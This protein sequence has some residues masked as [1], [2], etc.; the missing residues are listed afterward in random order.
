MYADCYDFMFWVKYSENTEGR[1]SQEAKN[2]CR[3]SAMAAHIFLLAQIIFIGHL[4]ELSF[5][6][7]QKEDV[8][9]QQSKCEQEKV[10]ISKTY[11]IN[12]TLV[13]CNLKFMLQIL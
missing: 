1:E 13:V 5:S 6:Y 3:R 12:V 10:S 11:P 8:E 2:V 7:S 9:F 4:T